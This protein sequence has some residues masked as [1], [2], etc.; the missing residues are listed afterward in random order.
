[1]KE[2][3]ILAILSVVLS[4][5]LDLKFGAKLIKKG[6]FHL[7]LL[8]LFVF[9]LILNGYLTSYIVM[10]DP[11][12]FMGVRLGRIPIEDFLFGFSM[13][14]CAINFFEFFKDRKG[15]IG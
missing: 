7:L 15:G 3:T 12:F 6:E 14:L 10:Y 2:Y 8:I 5:Y 1:M 13:T 4:S 9:M 11:K